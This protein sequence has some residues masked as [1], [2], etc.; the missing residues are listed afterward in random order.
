[1]TTYY[2][3]E[4]VLAKHPRVASAHRA[5][6][7]EKRL[8]DGKSHFP[9]KHY[10]QTQR[11]WMVLRGDVEATQDERFTE[12]QMDE[13][14]LIEHSTKEAKECFEGAGR[15]NPYRGLTV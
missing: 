1:M 10:R 8:D 12:R 14:E 4:L 5:E 6:K 11:H 2:L 15:K 13:C 7:V 3:I 9:K